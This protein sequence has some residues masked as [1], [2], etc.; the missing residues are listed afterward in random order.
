MRPIKFRAWARVNKFMIHN[1][2]SVLENGVP[3][4]PYPLVPPD[5]IWQQF[6]GLHDKN[7]KEIWEGDVVENCMRFKSEHRNIAEV[8]WYK[9]LGC[10]GLIYRGGTIQAFHHLFLTHSIG[11]ER[12]V[13]VLGNIYENPDLLK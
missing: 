2:F 1:I 7:G 13:E 10:W 12:N 3:D 5:L 11:A 4:L 6:T 9:D 8:I